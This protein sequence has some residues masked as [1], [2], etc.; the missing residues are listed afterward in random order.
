MIVDFPLI[1]EHDARLA[2][3]YDEIPARLDSL[4]GRVIEMFRLYARMKG[5]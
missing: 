3:G 2:A 5:E 1:W 4:L